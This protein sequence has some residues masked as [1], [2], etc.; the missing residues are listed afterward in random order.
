MRDRWRRKL[1]K[2]NDTR[3]SGFRQGIE[4]IRAARQHR[5][6]GTGSYS[7]RRRSLFPAIVA[8]AIVAGF[9]APFAA[10]H[11]G[12]IGAAPP[13]VASPSV[14][15]V[16]SRTP[17]AR[18]IPICSGRVRVTCIVDGDTGWHDGQKWRLVARSGGVD[19]PEISKPECAAERS[20][21]DRATRRLQALM[22]GGYTL[23]GGDYDRYDR[24]LVTVMLADGRDAGE[25]L[26]REGLAQPWPNRGNPWC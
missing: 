12:L 15:Q 6:E 4:P 10:Q 8:I 14:V 9:G 21:G 23:S 5:H 2:L 24:R 7:P 13:A 3:G 25:V 19:A 11:F 22:S 1:D 20:A 16:S 17:T 18:H 26:L